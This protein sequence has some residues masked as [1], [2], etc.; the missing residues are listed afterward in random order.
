M[1]YVIVM[2]LLFS[3]KGQ[4]GGADTRQGSG[5]DQDQDQGRPKCSAW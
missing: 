2:Y 1:E 4:D 3:G 5:Q